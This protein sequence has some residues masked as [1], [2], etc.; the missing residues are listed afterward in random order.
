MHGNP[1]R[2]RPRGQLMLALYRSGRQAEALQIY[3]DT[4]RTLVDELGIEPTRALQELHASILRQESVLQPQDV[5]SS[6]WTGSARSRALSSPDDSSSS[7]AQALRTRTATRSPT[8]SPKSSTQ[9]HEYP[10]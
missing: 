3:Q 7:S 8:D 10:W 2:E 5:S 6:A 1:L 9:P 4:R